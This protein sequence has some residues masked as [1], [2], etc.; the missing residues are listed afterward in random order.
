[1]GGGESVLHYPS[2]RRNV[3]LPAVSQS[4]EGVVL[5]SGK[6]F[7]DH[8]VQ[9]HVVGALHAYRADA[10]EVLN[11]LFYVLLYDSVVLGD[12]YSFAGENCGLEGA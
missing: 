6:L 9:N 2:P 4:L 8:D 12:A 11:G 1:M 7:A 5:T 10:A 3:G